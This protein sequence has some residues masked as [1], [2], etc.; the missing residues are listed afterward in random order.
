MS[1]RDRE[2]GGTYAWYVLGVMVVV[3][4]FNFLDRQILAILAE[5]I[6]ADLGLSDSE[7]GF[8]YGTAFA[9]FYAVFGIPLGR[10]ADTWVRRSV[11]SIGL[12]VWS[13]MTALS[14]FAHT[15]GQL[16]GARI[17][18]GVGEASASP[19]AYSL[20]SDYFPPER[21]ATVMAIYSSGLYVGAGI[22]L[23]L[24]GYIVDSWNAAW[25]DGGAPLGLHGWQAAFLVVGFPGLLVAAWVRTVKEPVRG[26]SDG[27][28][29]EASSDE[30]WRVL[31]RELSAVIPPFTLMS[32]VGR[33][34]GRTVIAANLATAVAVVLMAA[35]MTAWLGDAIQ[36]Y[37]LALGLYSTVSWV[38]GLALSDRAAFVVIFTSRALR[39]SVVG[40]SLIAFG[41]Y[42]VG[43][44]TV[45][46]FLREFGL[47]A[48]E[49]GKMLGLIAAVAGWL[50]AT[51]GGFAADAWQR[52]S[53]RG[54]IYFSMV[55][56]LAPLPFVL[57]LVRTDNLT[58]AYAMAF[59]AQV[60]NGMWL[61]AAVSTVQDLVLPR[62][63]AVAS[64]VYLLMLTFVGLAMGPYTV[65][66][67]SEATGDLGG[68][69]ET[70][71]IA[72]VAAVVVLAAAGR[73]V[74]AD[75]DSLIDRARAAGETV[76]VESPRSG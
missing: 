30:P 20:L 22:G 21:R 35:A 13:L 4:V 27:V 44:W 19:S 59:G 32:L 45:P 14:G 29:A 67:V 49:V 63:R 76:T 2:P 7:I 62:M 23:F 64:A 40:F 39:Y 8:L 18:V 73:L 24:G 28:V 71:M 72:N 5:D 60:A 17:G 52:R 43:F 31:G 47:S 48:T 42:S 74:A 51:V 75:R 11:I 54:R 34:A 9:V 3:Y 16:A 1:D 15:F 70:A 56:A 6:K 53:P 46:F 25:P 26:A 37:A 10:L 58:L 57:G 50:G 33:G 69:I 61:G 65:G 12:T 41:S 36:W 38:Q 68:A 55:S 66:R